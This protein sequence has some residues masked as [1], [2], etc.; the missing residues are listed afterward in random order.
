MVLG[1]RSVIGPDAAMLGRVTLRLK[2][3]QVT[4]QSIRMPPFRCSTRARW[5]TSAANFGNAGGTRDRC[6]SRA[7]A[8]TC[9]SATSSTPAASTLYPPGLSVTLA[10]RRGAA[11]RESDFARILLAARR[12]ITCTTY[13]CWAAGA[14]RQPPPKPSCP[15]VQNARPIGLGI[16]PANGQNDRPGRALD[17]H[18]ARLNR[19][20]CGQPSS[21][22]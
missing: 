18:A 11:R 16:A 21:S 7:P 6:A 15:T 12:P 22:R 9:R 1:A 10:N 17:D 4:R 8:P 2:D 5:R 14:T 3:A 20:C 19:C 13:W